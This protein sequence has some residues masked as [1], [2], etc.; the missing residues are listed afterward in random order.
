MYIIYINPF[1]IKLSV[2][3]EYLPRKYIFVVE[4]IKIIIAMPYIVMKSH[5]IYFFKYVC[6][7]FTQCKSSSFC[8][9]L[10][11]TNYKFAFLKI[12]LDIKDI[13]RKQYLRKNVVWYWE[14]K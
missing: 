12:H 3:C 2:L 9:I 4:M 10:T 11:V 6:F 14:K 7:Q 13:K 8:M 1:G 5:C